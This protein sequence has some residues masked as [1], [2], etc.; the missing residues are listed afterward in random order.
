MV[1]AQQDSTLVKK[2][3]HRAVLRGS[4]VTFYGEFFSNSVLCGAVDKALENGKALHIMGL[5]S[6]GGVHSH[7]GQ[8]LSMVE[9]AAKRGLKK[10]Y[11]HAFLDGRDVP[12]KSAAETIERMEAK[13]V[14]LGVGRFASIVGRFYAMDRDNRWERVENAYN[15]IAKGEA[16]FQA[17]SAEQGL[18]MAYQRGET[19][20]FVSATVIMDEK[21]LPVRLDTE[22]SIIFM[23]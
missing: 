23:N 17:D 15:L 4:S 16:D 8:I 18:E 5:L 3:I 11:V 1:R 14:E 22:D 6:P 19:D 12:P 2:Y 10:I 20:E 7:I 9:L 13:F 21:N